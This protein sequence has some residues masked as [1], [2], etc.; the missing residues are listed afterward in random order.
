[1]D[2]FL[3]LELKSY[4][5]SLT[6]IDFSNWLKLYY[7]YKPII[8]FQIKENPKHLLLGS[9]SLNWNLQFENNLFHLYLSKAI[10]YPAEKNSFILKPSVY[11]VNIHN[12]QKW[13]AKNECK[14]DIK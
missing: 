3:T 9:V 4:H 8:I 6:E 1:M 14:N 12:N 13:L 7:I 2:S 5:L 10:N 11:Y